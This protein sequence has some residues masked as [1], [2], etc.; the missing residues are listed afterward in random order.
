VAEPFNRAAFL[1]ALEREV[2]WSRRTG[3]PF[4]VAFLD[5]D[6]F[7]PVND[8]YG[9][10]TGDEVLIEVARRL[11]HEVRASD[12]VCRLG[13]D[14][15]VLMLRNLVHSEEARAILER[16]VVTLE[17]PY[18][19][20]AA[21]IHGITASIGYARFPDDAL[22]AER[23]LSLADEAMYEAKRR[24]KGVIVRSGEAVDAPPLVPAIQPATSGNRVG[25]GHLA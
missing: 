24:G 22:D 25:A 5:L 17:Q 4:T 8:R 9:H 13:G 2:A 6:G 11:D 1:A 7:K 20:E 14:E 19:V 15:F 16:V 18:E 21:H 3:K 12:T 23:L 10:H